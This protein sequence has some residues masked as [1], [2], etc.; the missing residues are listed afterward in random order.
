MA[1]NDQIVKDFNDAWARLNVDELMNYFTEDAVY[2]NIPMRPAVGTASI[3]KVITSL[4]KGVNAI[5]F[6]VHHQISIGNVV[7]NERTD[8]TEM[9]EKKMSLPV[10]GVFEFENGKIKAWRDY[11]DMATFSNALAG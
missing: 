11:F 8:Y 10:M 6:E 3:R 9:G 5:R 2:H 1:S 4:L 7:M